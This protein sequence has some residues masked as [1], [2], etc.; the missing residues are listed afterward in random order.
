MIR[1]FPPEE[2]LEKGEIGKESAGL[3]EGE[4]A[5]AIPAARELRMNLRLIIGILHEI[6]R[7][8]LSRILGLFTVRPN[9][10][11]LSHTVENGIGRSFP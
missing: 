11:L 8:G 1:G 3:A 7:N 5:A 4:A 2:A 6:R 9:K 10:S